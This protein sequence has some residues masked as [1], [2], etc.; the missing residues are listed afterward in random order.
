MKTK[1]VIIILFVGMVL[2]TLS[3]TVWS[4][5]TPCPIGFNIG[6]T[7][8][9][10]GTVT[11]VDGPTFYLLGKD[12]LIYTISGDGSEVVVMGLTGGGYAPR[13]GDTVRVYGT[14]VDGC[15]IQAARIRLYKHDGSGYGA[16]P[17]V[18]APD[19]EIKIIIEK[20]PAPPECGAETQVQAC[21]TNWEARGLIMDIDYTGNRLKVRTSDGLYSVNVRNALLEKGGGRIGLGSVNP[22]DAV[23]V[24]GN[25]VGLN[26][27]DA[28]QVRVTRTRDEAYNA[29]PELPASVIGVIQQ[30]DYQSMTFKMLTER[31]LI[32]VLAD[33]NTKLQ[34]QNKRMAF[35]DLKPGMRI[36][37]SGYG[38]P[39]NGYVAHHIQIISLSP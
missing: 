26:E 34:I 20:R 9:A 19:K 18:K 37:M 6:R 39:G 27:I 1:R 16:G 10:T 23:R 35:M 7:W 30:I 13:V 14:V 32:V 33:T 31:S 15:R 38:N 12:N 24:T 17:G 21:P 25:L 3:Y 29:L 28:R 36:K 5:Q 8:L 4:A 11:K 22:G 2:M